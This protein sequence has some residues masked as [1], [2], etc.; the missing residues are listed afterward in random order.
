ME[1]EGGKSEGK[2]TCVIFLNRP[3]LLL[4]V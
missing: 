3:P 2:I 4:V 1:N